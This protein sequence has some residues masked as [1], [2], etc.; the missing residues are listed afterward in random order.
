MPDSIKR[1]PLLISALLLLAAPAAADEPPAAAE[2]APMGQIA[3]PQHTPEQAARAHF[4]RG[5]ALY[6]ERNYGGAWLEFTSA[7]EL[8]KKP[9]LLYNMARCERRLGRQAQARAHLQEYLRAEPNDPDRAAIENELRELSA[10]LDQ[11]RSGPRPD[12]PDAPLLPLEPPKRP[13]PTR[14]VVA[15]GVTVALLIAG[16]AVL[17]STQSKYGEL[18]DTC[19]PN[20]LQGPVDQLRGQAI[21]GYVLMGLAGAGAVTTAVLLAMD[22]RRD[23]GAQRVTLRPLVGPTF[24]LAG[25]F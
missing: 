10:D 8:S 25:S 21:A 3:T 20:C 22:L 13:F 23:R 5:A 17:G 12:G 24:G 9:K 7:Y 15:G 14:G 16:G 6:Q 4:M 19:A 2:P 18:R 11:P 1:R